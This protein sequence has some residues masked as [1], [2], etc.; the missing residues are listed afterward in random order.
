MVVVAESGT[1]STGV[2][3]AAVMVAV[4]AGGTAAAGTEKWMTVW[5]EVGPDRCA[6]KG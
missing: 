4:A 2:S 6:W 1:V 3:V 5:K